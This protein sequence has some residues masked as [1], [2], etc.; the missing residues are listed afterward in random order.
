MGIMRQ[1]ATFGGGCFW[2]TEAIFRPLKGV[3]TVTSGYAGGRADGPSY[4]HVS[5]G[6]TGHAEAVRIEFDPSL[7]TYEQ[8]VEVFFLTH[9]PTAVNRQGND[10]GPQYRSVIFVH[11]EEQRRTAERLKARLEAE[12]VFDRPIVTAIEPLRNFFPAEAEHQNYY[13]KNAAQ[14]YCQAVISPKVA[15]L[16]AKF[17]HLLTPT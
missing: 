2:C 10:V 5:T 12:G 15:A 8:L 3:S 13:A 1:R 17:A 11:D 7:V 9:D 4:E 6:R 16:R 14:P